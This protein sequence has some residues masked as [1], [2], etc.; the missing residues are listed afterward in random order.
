MEAF[1]KNKLIYILLLSSL[2]LSSCSNNHIKEERLLELEEENSRLTNIN[3]NLITE[4]EN[5]IKK[6]Q[7]N[8]LEIANLEMEI[9]LLKNRNNDLREVITSLEEDHTKIIVDN[10]SKVGYL[11]YLKTN[12]K[13]GKSKKE[14]LQL[15]E[16]DYVKVLPVE[17]VSEIWRFDIGTNDG[18]KYESNVDT[19]DLDGL[20][21]ES[22]SLILFLIWNNKD[23]LNRYVIYY[24]NSADG[25]IKEC[26][27][28]DNEKIREIII[29][30]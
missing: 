26:S 1:L 28:S 7:E 17:G 12:L 15:I 24:K 13:S 19:V 22:V 6:T 23:E 10:Y 3:T 25:S 5:A 27:L 18:Y 29:R 20:S 11:D 4:N 14:I 30:D 16:F 9:K 21:S 2:V 8:R